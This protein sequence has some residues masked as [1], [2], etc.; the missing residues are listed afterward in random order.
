MWKSKATTSI[1]F[2]FILMMMMLGGSVISDDD[3]FSSSLELVRID[4]PSQDSVGVAFLATDSP[5]DIDI[6]IPGFMWYYFYGP[7]TAFTGEYG[8]FEVESGG[9][10][11]FF[12]CTE[13]NYNLWSSGESSYAY[14]IHN[15]V[16]SASWD[17]IF[18]LTD[19]W[20]KVYDN[21]YNY[22]QAH[23]T[24]HHTVDRTAPVVDINLE[25]GDTYSGV[26]QISVSATD[27]SFS[28]Y[29][30]GLEIDGVLVDGE[31]GSTL[32]YNW[33]TQ[34]YDDGPHTI[35]VLSEDNVGN[36]GS[37]DISVNVSNFNY[38]ALGVLGLSG[39]ALVAVVVVLVTKRKP[40]V[41]APLTSAEPSSLGPHLGEGSTANF[42]PFCGNPRGPPGVKFCQNCGGKLGG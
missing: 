29:Q 30:I 9:G 24:G 33:D 10:I 37:I 22:L 36:S 25:D 17:F 16:G 40:S 1:I 8:E 23:V 14:E 39:I 4:P 42:C 20:Y 19:T 18:T 28:V 41:Q 38:V 6:Y 2:L 5:N 13:D 32:D 15:S 3:T 21:S 12:I 26:T 11:N 35:T 31:Y 34:T 7:R 27:A